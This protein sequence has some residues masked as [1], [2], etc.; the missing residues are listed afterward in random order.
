M[1]NFW[2]LSQEPAKAFPILKSAAKIPLP[3]RSLFQV[4]SYLTHSVFKVV[5]QKSIPTQ[6]CE[7]ILVNVKDKLTDL[8]GS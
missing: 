4:R 8:W 2:H 6:I 7:L 5:L 1:V 3:P